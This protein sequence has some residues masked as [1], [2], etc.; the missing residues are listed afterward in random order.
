MYPN[1]GTLPQG[2]PGPLKASALRHSLIPPTA[3]GRLPRAAVPPEAS[4][5]LCILHSPSK[6]LLELQGTASGSFLLSLLPA[7]SPVLHN[8]PR[9]GPPGLTSSPRRFDHCSGV[10]ASG[11]QELLPPSSPG[12]PP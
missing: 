11:E 4:H 12:S 9:T 5:G 2:D 8:P 7:P 6:A 3:P 10:E 1:P